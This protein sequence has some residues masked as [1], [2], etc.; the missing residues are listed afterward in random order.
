MTSLKAQVMLVDDHAMVRQGM[1]SLINSEPDLAVVAE[2]E[3]A[4]QALKILATAQKIDIVL[5]DLTLKDVADLDLIHKMNIQFPDLPMLVVSMHNEKVYA[6]R[7]LKS[8]ARGYVMKQEPG[9]I[10]ISAIREVLKGNIFLSQPMTSLFLNRNIKRK[11]EQLISQLTHS[12]I[13]ILQMIASGLG[14]QEIALLTNRSKKTIEAHRANIR[15]K[16]NL[17]NSADL[18]RYATLKFSQAGSTK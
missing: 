10:L 6:E 15:F 7:A 17:K 9:E 16:L 12:E 8:G 4:E 2:A 5:L 18:I 13:E 14:S 3:S 11:P 1:S